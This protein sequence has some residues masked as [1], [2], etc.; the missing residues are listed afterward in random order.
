MPGLAEDVKVSTARCAPCLALRSG[1]T[2]FL[3]S[4]SIWM[5]QLAQTAKVIPRGPAPLPFD[6]L[7]RS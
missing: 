7:Q 1:I 3:P 5:D 2:D 6:V 4:S